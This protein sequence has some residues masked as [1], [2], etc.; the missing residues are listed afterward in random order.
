MAREEPIAVVVVVVAV[1]VALDNIVARGGT[2]EALRRLCVEEG[3]GLLPHR[4]V[5][6]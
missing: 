4:V 5:V 3:C 2:C 6:G 1:M